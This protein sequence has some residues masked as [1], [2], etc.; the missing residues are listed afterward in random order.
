MD[1]NLSFDEIYQ[2]TEGFFS[3]RSDLAYLLLGMLVSEIPRNSK[4]PND[5]LRVLKKYEKFNS[6]FVKIGTNIPEFMDEVRERAMD[7]NMHI[8][9]FAEGSVL[10]QTFKEPIS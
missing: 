2:A 8:I 9:K 7:N 4:D 3:E 1:Q 10:K 5:K 6:E